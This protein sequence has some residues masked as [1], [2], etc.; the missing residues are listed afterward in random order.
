MDNKNYDFNEKGYLFLKEVYN[1]E[2]IESFN[3][4]IREFMEKNNIYIHLKKRHDVVEDL[5][6]VNNTYVSLDNYN[7]IQY[8]Y[9]PVI[10]N[11]GGRNRINDV[12]MI[13]IYNADK[14]FPKIFEKFNLDVI[15]SILYKITGNKWKLLRTNIQIC[16]NVQNPNSFHF[17]N[18]NKCIKYTIYL[19]NISSEDNG[20]PLYIENS[21]I[22]KNNI[23]N[24]H[25]KTFMGNKGDVLISFQ[26]G[27]HR[28]LPQN[29][30]T[31]GFLVFNFIPL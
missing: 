9:L 18:V 29:N 15:L 23:K 27:I 2:I 3:K 22:V 10:D 30:Y 5:F 14:L 8:Y 28:K 26:N 20:P 25:I 17:E 24:S 11:R 16:S 6:Y 12:G 4:E 19:S 1:L 7:K 31:C 21:H 13:D